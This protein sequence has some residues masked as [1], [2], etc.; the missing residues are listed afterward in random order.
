MRLRLIG[1]AAGGGLP[2]WNCRCENCQAARKRLRSPMTQCSLAFCAD[3]ATWYLINATSDVGAQLARW[4]E[5]HPAAEMRSTPIRGV[6]LTDGEIDHT[7]GLLQLREGARWTVYATPAVS[8]LIQENLPL[9]SALRRYADVPAVT[10]LPD[11]PRALCL[12]GVEVRLVETG[13]RLP[14]YAGAG[15]TVGAVVAVILRDAV[16]GKRVVFAPGVSTLT[17]SLREWCAQADAILFDGTFWSDDEL[18][19]L[20]IGADTAH[21]MGHLPVGGCGGSGRWLAE[22]P[23][24]TKLYVHVNNT[25]PLLD[26]ASRERA[27]ITSL[28]LEVGYDGWTMTL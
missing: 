1:A 17:E 15:E 19:D 3:G 2:Q 22:L 23:A 21:A 24:R 9:L 7:L 6:F 14:R 10:L 27:W 8:R 12:P 11:A 13:R 28:G 25:N 26:P 4:P 20:G 5:L 18:R 16:S